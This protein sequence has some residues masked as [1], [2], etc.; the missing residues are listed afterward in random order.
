MRR[1]G[2]VVRLNDLNGQFFKLARCVPAW[3]DRL[4]RLD[5]TACPGLALM[6]LQVTIEVIENC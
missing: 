5:S 1:G 6:V 2:V 3:F 4:S